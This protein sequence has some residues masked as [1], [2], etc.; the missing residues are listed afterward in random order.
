[1]T[2][3]HRRTLT[4][5]SAVLSALVLLL[6]TAGSV[7]AQG[8]PATSPTPAPSAGP[9]ASATP[10]ASPRPQA[11]PSPQ[12]APTPPASQPIQS[13]KPTQPTRPAQP[14]KPAPA[15]AAPG[16]VDDWPTYLHDPQRT[17]ASAETTLGPGNVAQLGRSWALKT[18]GPIA[19]SATIVAGTAYVGSWDGFEY[20]VDAATGAIKWKAFLGTTTGGAG[21]FPRTAGVSSAP[22][23]LNGVVYLGGGDSN[24]YALD[25]NT[26]AVLWT[27]PTGDNSAAGGH[28]N[29]ASPLLYNGY[30]YVGISSLG[31]CPLVQGQ[32]LQV[33]LTTHQV[34]NTF[35]AAPPGQTG[36]GIWTTPVV[37]P[38]TNTIFVT[39]GTTSGFNEPLAQ[40]MVSLDATSLAVKGYWTVPP[41]QTGVDSDWG[42]SP[43]LF[44]D[45]A[46]HPLVAGINKGG[47]AYGFN[48]NNISAGPVWQQQIAKGGTCS[49]CGD[50]S[51][52]SGAFGNG[53]LYFAG[54]NTTINGV[55][56]PG[57]VRALDPATGRF[58]WEHPT[59]APVVPALAYANGMVIAGAGATLEV[60]DAASGTRL[61]SYTTGAVIYGSP[62]VSTGRIFLGSTDGNEYA[63]GLT[64]VNPPPPDPN[65]SPGWT[66]QD[67][68]APLPAGSEAV[69]GGNWAIQAGGAGVRGTADQFRMMNRA[70]VGDAQITAR[71]TAQQATN[72]TAQAGLMI[73][74]SND[75]G[76]PYYAVFRTPGTGVTVQYR[77]QFGGVT[78]TV[79]SPAKG[80]PVYL[81][82]QRRGDHFQAATA[83]DGINYTLIPGTDATVV[84]PAAALVGLAA[85]S[86]VNGTSG[87]VRFTGV[88]VGTPGA[89]PVAPPPASACPAGWSCRDVGNP[90]LVGDQTLAGGVWTVK[91]AGND[92][93]YYSDQFHYVWQPVAGDT[94][95]TAR[96]ATQTNTSPGAKAGIMLRQSTD[97]GSPF[98]GVFVTPGAG[99]QVLYRATQGLRIL[100]PAAT[101][102]GTVP[103]YFQVQRSGNVFSTF[104]SADGVNWTYL[105]DSA[106]TVYG[107]AGLAGLAV[108]SQ[109]GG[110]LGTA[111]FTQVRVTP[112]A[113]PPP[114]ACLAGWSCADIGY[115]TPAGEQFFSNGVW[116]VG[117]GGT[118]IW[119]PYDSFHYVWQ[120]LAGDGS[121]SARVATQTNTDPSAKAG[122]M[123]RQS[124]DPGA[125]FFAALATPGN[126]I[127]IQYRTTQG[128]NAVQANMMPGAVPAYLEVA[129][130]GN[131]FSAYTSPD[132]ATW[133]PVA[134]SSVALFGGPALAGMA[135]TSHNTANV[136]SVTF[137]HVVLSLTAPPPAWSCFAVWSC[138]DIGQ[139][140]PAG[141]Q[142]LNNGTW[143]IQG[144]GSDIF[145]T[146]DQ[147]HFVWQTVPGDGTVSA[148][149]TAQTNSD[150]WA[151]A[152]VMLRQ[153]ADP[154]AAYYF[155][156]VTPSNGIQ[157]QYRLS[158]GA[159]AAELTGFPATVPAY[160]RVARSGSVLCAYS[161]AD[162]ATWSYIRGSCIVLAGISGPVY[163]GMAVTSH[164]GLALSTVTMDSVAITATAPPPPV[165]CPANWNCADIGNPGLPGDQALNNGAWTVDGGG[166]DIWGNADQF[167]YVWQQLP[168]DG[169]VSG[170][171]VSQGNSDP[172]AKGGLMIRQST[173]PA[174]PYY[175]VFVTPGHGVVVQYRATQGGASAAAG[176]VA[177]APPAY[178]RVTVAAGSFTAY[179]SADGVTWTAIPGSTVALGMTA[180][181][182]AGM[183]VTAHNGG[184]ISQVV[185][186]TVSV[187]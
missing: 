144:G 103:A 175:A 37:D 92:I 3:T 149:I 91:G 12:A 84:L 157:I 40:A 166:S 138:Q 160:L 129:R 7:S 122:V 145:Q 128:S 136:S 147:F 16:Q 183:A 101:V 69:Q 67:I 61:Y 162:G 28:Y 70:V 54:G 78:T 59:A 108:T 10:S 58:V 110:K 43:I 27:V 118:D 32:L 131:I 41:A 150:P 83:A 66:C 140:S 159:A 163:G 74:Q 139:P 155:A 94:T 77:T 5:P 90:R 57:F 65:C 31:D 180:P 177:G 1:M 174:S 141:G 53:L 111:T 99:I 167:H 153:S 47:W 119:G 96:V 142:T 38:A 152:G 127:V 89:A 21:C 55:G 33:N 176:P 13:P 9:Q 87:A 79:Q 156:L 34:V 72:P 112:N 23:V 169:S 85:T 132:G 71:L 51:V 184:A 8:S 161:S 115:P 52:S 86:A 22:T 81:E 120:T 82:V 75:A 106:R 102:P 49:P 39:T 29:W 42:T 143:Q 170:R 17:G 30:A 6:L 56:T 25:A 93:S 133:T 173:D 137:D 154:A 117:A 4:L 76:S 44:A 50:A 182:L 100:P 179:T 146:S 48:R 186:D 104:T 62:S 95:V 20:A 80:L 19:A 36:G 24:W 46:G 45:A 148:H 124:A 98:Y 2:P 165:F 18:G 151:K 109:N 97:P 35:N 64:A 168:G 105:L 135:A 121:F 63:F 123:L 88:A 11:S 171:V 178:V 60:L 68:G 113:P 158:Q 26:G 73:R 181:S 185:I 107:G 134:G 172:W 187:G 14:T 15:A 164:N 130:S 125:P 116:T 114:T 126:G